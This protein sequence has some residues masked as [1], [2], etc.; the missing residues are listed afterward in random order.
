MNRVLEYVFGAKK[1]SKKKFLLSFGASLDILF[2]LSI[3]YI[4]V[5]ISSI[6]SNFCI[7]VFVQL[8]CGPRE[9]RK[10]LSFHEV[11]CDASYG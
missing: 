10:L 9:K 3:S 2:Q 8:D 6:R 4:N 7:P 11:W 1:M 5:T